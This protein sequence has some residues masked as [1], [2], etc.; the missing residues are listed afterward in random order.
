M[1]TQ[2]SFYLSPKEAD[3]RWFELDASDNI[4]GRLASEIASILR[5][6]RRPTFTPG[7]D[8][9]DYVVVTNAHKV[10][11]T[12]RKWKQKKYYR[13]SGH[14]GGLKFRTAEEQK[15]IRP[16]LIITLAVKGMLPKTSLGKK[17]LKKLKV[18]AGDEHPHGAQNP[19]KIGL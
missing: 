14:V 11:L 2:K 10:R 5:G 8:C 19:K 17:Q 15:K 4:L 13:H 16:D 1:R 9:G 3:E 18:Y 7:A 6:K 12:G